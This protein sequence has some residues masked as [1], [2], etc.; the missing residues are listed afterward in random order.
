M[1]QSPCCNC[2]NR[3]MDKNICMLSCSLIDKI[4]RI[5]ASRINRPFFSAVDSEDSDRY[6]LTVAFDYCSPELSSLPA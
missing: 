6:H 2:P 4:Q 1:I 3:N 5:D